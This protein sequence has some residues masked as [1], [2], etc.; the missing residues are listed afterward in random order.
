MRQIR[1]I[2]LAA[3]ICATTAHAAVP[4]PGLEILWDK[5]GVAHVSAKNNVDL[6]Y[7]YGWATAHSHGNLLLKL[8][9]QSRGRGA[10]LYGATD[11]KLN[12]WVLTNGLPERAEAWYKQQT[13]EFRKYLDAFAR[14]VNDYAAKYPGRLS[15]EAKAIL[16]VT[17]V[18]P[19]LHSLRVVHYTFVSSAQRV[20]AA[21][22]GAVAR[23]EAGG[24]NAWAVGP[25]KSA[26]GNTMLLGNPHLAWQD[27]STYYEI[28][29]KSPGIDL[30]GASQVGFPVL[31]FVFSDYLGFNQTVNTIDAVDIYRLTV[32]GGR[33][34]YDGEWKNFELAEKEFK[35]RQADGS[36]K[37][38]KLT[39]RHSIQGPVVYEKQGLTLALRVAGLD[40]PF[41]LEQY[42]QMATSRNFDQFR[43]AAARNQVPM[44]NVVY[45][46]RDGH[47]MYLFNGTVPKRKSG[48]WK[49]WQGIVPGD[50]SETMWSSYHT[51]EEL[52]KVIDPPAGY[53][54]NTNDPPWNASWPQTLD[55]EKF[56]PY[57][58][59]KTSSFRNER[60]IRLM[61]QHGKITYADFLKYKHDTHSELADR[62]L[63]DL[64]KAVDA[65]GSP[66]AK[67]AAAVLKAWDRTVDTDSRG[68]L[69]FLYWAQRF[70]GPA[71]ADQSRFAVPYDMHK[72]LETPR[73]LKDPANAAVLLEAAAT[74]LETEVGALDTKWGDVMK[75]RRGNLELPANG[76]F[77]NLGIFRVITFG[78]MKE[79]KRE[80]IHGETY[81]VMIEFGKQRATARALIG[82][83]NSSQPG[84]PHIEDQLEFMTRKE[85]RPV[86]RDRKEIEANLELREAF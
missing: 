80:P 37:S 77:G 35:V 64:V 53:V 45:A 36:L 14:G 42:W 67:A 16:P 51:Y 2:L 60:S 4:S 52:P 31:R 15:P 29:L 58:S 24:S 44:Y 62:I 54:Q 30:Y 81:V 40:R 50:T 70:M 27:L 7:G 82:Y 76:G 34:K 73:G 25:K 57:M 26:S 8:Y 21:A 17:G 41:M 71:M 10:E 20:E 48:D 28:H 33:Y 23:T 39:I 19:L 47:I 12:R 79:K 32:D 22:T 6:F 84:S 85:L 43:K 5:Y 11:L 55:T 69:L 66:K 63:D 68:S 49:F 1:S 83:G 13:P 56:P 75:Y 38:E 61:S 78:P 3:A 72:P 86:W 59:P 65:N 46:D 9:A 18:D 74:A